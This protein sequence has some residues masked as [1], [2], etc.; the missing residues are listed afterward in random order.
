MPDKVQTKCPDI[1]IHRVPT[2]RESR[3]ILRESGKTDRVKEKSGNFKIL[4]SGGFAPGPLPG[5]RPSKHCRLVYI[6]I[7]YNGIKFSITF[8][9]CF[10]GV[11]NKE[12][13]QGKLFILSGKVRENLFCKVVET[14]DT[15]QAVSAKH[16]VNN[17]K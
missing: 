4:A 6:A 1:K 17:I 11:A 10:T 12:I 16:H 3:G 7:F 8:V 2:V 9:Y 5:L 13:S 15:S 14:L